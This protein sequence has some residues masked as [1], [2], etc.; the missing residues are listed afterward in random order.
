MNFP[1]KTIDEIKEALKEIKESKNGFISFVNY[2]RKIKKENFSMNWIVIKLGTNASLLIEGEDFFNCLQRELNLSYPKTAF[3]LG[4]N[5]NNETFIS[6]NKLII[7]S[8]K[9][10]VDINSESDKQKFFPLQHKIGEIIFNKIDNYIQKQGHSFNK[11]KVI[12]LLPP[13]T[14][15]KRQTDI[16][17]R[18]T[19][20]EADIEQINLYSR[21]DLDFVSMANKENLPKYKKLLEEASKNINT[22]YLIIQDECHWGMTKDGVL[23]R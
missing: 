12:L 7:S 10:K 3:Q 16:R 9:F 23:D 14:S 6:A 22:L 20:E 1:T 11:F 5:A 21:P 4:T 17:L 18:E 19:L 8:Y 2:E 13:R 15:L